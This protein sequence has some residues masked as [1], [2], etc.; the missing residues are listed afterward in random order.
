ML[1]RGIFCVAALGLIF[2]AGGHA[3]ENLTLAAVLGRLHAY[4]FD[5]AER[6]PATIASEH[7]VQRSGSGMRYQASTLDSDFGI[8]R[9]PG[10]PE[11]LGFRE[12]LFE[13]GR[14]ASDSEKKL[15]GAFTNPSAD[16]LEQARLITEES[17]RH[18][19]GAVYRTVNNPALVLELLDGRNAERMRF[20]RRGENTIGGVQAWRVRFEE[21]SRPTIIQVL[22]GGNVFASG[23]AWIDPANGTLMRAEVSFRAQG[24]GRSGNFSGTLTVDFENNARVGF[25]VPARMTE[26]YINARQVEVS[27][28]EA[29]YTNYRRFTVDTRVIIGAP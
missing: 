8:V 23:Q 12:V 24:T 11:W 18:N 14:A 22:D 17:A 4:L 25:W 1:H 15:E 5:Y 3:Q 7:Y 21:T 10:V 16:V 20:T 6:L 9:L 27:S 28:G 19:I 13:N 26:T 29:T 2:S